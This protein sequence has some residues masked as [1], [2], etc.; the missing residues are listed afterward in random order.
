[1]A[2]QI[3]TP[4]VKSGLLAVGGLAVTQMSLGIT[5]L[6]NYVPIGLAAAHQLGSLALLSSGIYLIHSFRYVS[7]PALL[8]G[9][10]KVA[11]TPVS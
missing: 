9:V 4:Q 1:L 7:R 11:S 6:L 10:K 3:V 5:T 8:R 2:K